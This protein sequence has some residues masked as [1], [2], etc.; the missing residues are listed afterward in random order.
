MTQKN[1]Y[2]E[3]AASDYN[4]SYANVRDLRSLIFD[5]RK[6]IVLDMLAPRGGRILDAGCG[7]GVY[8][9]RLIEAGCE[10]HGIDPAA[11]MIEIARGKSFKNSDFSIGSV[12][13]IKFA[14]G[15]FDGAICVG[16]LEYLPDID[17][18]IKEVARV[19]KKDA[20][21][22]FTV[23][24]GSSLLNKLD[25]A[26]RNSVKWIY[27]TCRLPFLKSVIT[28][29][30]QTRFIPVKEIYFAL[31][32]NGFEIERSRFHTFR[33]SFL[34]RL[35]PG[36]SLAVTKKMDFVSSPLIGIDH[37]IKCRKR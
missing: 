25:N 27:N 34:N 26:I 32:K 8:T 18:A 24:N 15:F 35:L 7:P 6:R 37:I 11:N 22:I 19:V 16:V 36:M 23:P 28:Y 3:S 13:D 31:R 21:V 1:G 9:D 4:A 17:T 14:D 12:E 10:V 33:L 30:Y 5:R 2:F 20:P 29:D